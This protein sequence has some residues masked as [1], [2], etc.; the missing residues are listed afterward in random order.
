MHIFSYVNQMHTPIC[1]FSVYRFIYIRLCSHPWLLL[2]LVIL[3]LCR[4]N[5]LWNE[6]RYCVSATVQVILLICQ[7]LFFFF[8]WPF[9]FTEKSDCDIIFNSR[10]KLVLSATIIIAMLVK[11]LQMI[12]GYVTSILMSDSLSLCLCLWCLK[13][14]YFISYWHYGTYFLF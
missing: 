3:F 10:I 7:H 13:D 11:V 14:I 1:T 4:Y 8:C 5:A 2:W 9:I 6:S 12:W